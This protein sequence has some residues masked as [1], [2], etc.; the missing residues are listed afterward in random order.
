MTTLIPPYYHP[1]TVCF[2]DDNYSFLRSIGMDF[3]NDWTF[4]S[5]LHPEEAL[6]FIDRVKP[7]KS[8]MTHISHLL[9]FHQEVE[10]ELPDNVFLA[11]DTL[12]ITI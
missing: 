11:Y 3:P 1:T 5:F 7:E 2:V 6:K 4:I 8:Y 12:K 10:N 9:G